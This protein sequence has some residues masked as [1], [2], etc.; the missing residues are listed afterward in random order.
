MKIILLVHKFHQSNSQ[1]ET[2]IFTTLF[3]VIISL[4]VY[5]FPPHIS[6]SNIFKLPEK[7]AW[8]TLITKDSYLPGVIA[9]VKSVQKTSSIYP[10]VVMYTNNVSE[11]SKNVLKLMNCELYETTP[12]YPRD[13]VKTNLAFSQF[14]EVW[15]KLRA[16]NIYG[17]DKLTYL[18]ADMLVIKNMDQIFD[19]LQPN[20][21]MAA[22]YACICNPRKF[23]HYPKHW[24]PSNCAHSTCK[25][26]HQ[27]HCYDSS[28]N[29]TH[30]DKLKEESNY[31]NSGLFLFRPNH[32]RSQKI[33]D[34]FHN[35]NDL[36]S[37]LFA[38][39]DFLNYYWK[40]NWR[41]LPFIYN[42]LKTMKLSHPDMWNYDQIKNI[43]FIIEKPWE[44]DL[45]EISK[46]DPYYEM[47]SKWWEIYLT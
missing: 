42:A 17:Y 22:S 43:H 31:F 4:G 21:E 46:E 47:L 23:S 15:T 6:N 8:V 40:G 30:F 20:E 1:M 45:N 33:I 38:D 13:G 27:T 37:F 44:K 41:P 12:L 25:E 7:N 28:N 3:V 39:Q 2:Q 24:N 36:S 35:F 19:Y 18:D 11:D 5:Y 34:T 16:W 29:K 32:I 14:S 10:F 26:Y 9:L